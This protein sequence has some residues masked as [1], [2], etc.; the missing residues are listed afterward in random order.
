MLSEFSPIDPSSLLRH[1]MKTEAPWD[2]IGLVGR[3]PQERPGFGSH[4]VEVNSWKP[5]SECLRNRLHL[6]PE[7]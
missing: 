1:L 4:G 7:F 2:W 5:I 6:S 3:G